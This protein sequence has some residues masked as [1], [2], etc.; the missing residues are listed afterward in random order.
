MMRHHVEPGDEM[1][2]IFRTLSHDISQ[3]FNK[4]D[5]QRIQHLSCAE[6]RPCRKVHF[7]RIYIFRYTLKGCE[8]LKLFKY[9]DPKFKFNQDSKKTDVQSS[10]KSH[11]LWVTLFISFWSKSGGNRGK[12]ASQSP[13][14]LRLY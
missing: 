3:H 2:E 6:G 13:N 12:F 10:L 4:D 9:D 7:Q 8:N 14:L 1:R 5:I 11:P